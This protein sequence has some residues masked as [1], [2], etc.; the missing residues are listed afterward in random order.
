MLKFKYE[1]FPEP[2]LIGVTGTSGKTTVTT[3]VYR[4]L[5][6]SGYKCLL[7]GTSGYYGYN[8]IYESFKEASN[9]TPMLEEIYDLIY[10]ND[11]NYDYVIMEASSQGLSLGRLMGL[12]FCRVVF[13]NLNPEHL[14]YH[15]N[16]EN[17]LLAKLKLFRQL[18]TEGYGIIGA[19]SSYKDKFIDG[20][21]SR[22]QRQLKGEWIFRR[23]LNGIGIED[24]FICPS[25]ATR[26]TSPQPDG[27]YG[28]GLRIYNSKTHC[29]DMVYACKSKFTNLCF[30]MEN[31]I[32][33]GTVLENPNRKWRFVERNENTFHW[34]NITIQE[35]GDITVNC[36]VFGKRKSEEA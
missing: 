16:M 31:G 25:R 23:V 34:Q 22:P 17:Y 3:L 32:L 5:K 26:E 28:V 15:H 19:E 11:F 36:E 9:T 6:R 18:T 29:Y 14:D 13:L 7:I 4:I 21:R 10:N 12:K 30:T 24:M 20:D 27:E 8:Q 35:N 2:N 33:T 1:A